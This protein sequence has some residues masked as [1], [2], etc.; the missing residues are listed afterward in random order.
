M[1][2]FDITLSK[3]LADRL[4]VALDDFLLVDLLRQRIAQ[5]EERR[6]G[7]VRVDRFR[8]EAR[9]A[10]EVMHLARAAGLDHEPA[11]RAQPRAHQVVVH[12]AVASN[13]GI[14]T[15]SEDTSRSVRMM[16]FVPLRTASSAS[17]QSWASA[18]SIP[19]AP[20]SPGSTSTGCRS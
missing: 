17:A 12:G 19:S 13:A 18:G 20:H 2:I 8:A 7:E 10:G 11:T 4:D 14:G 9:E 5:V 15:S 3:P 6:E 16:M 1:P